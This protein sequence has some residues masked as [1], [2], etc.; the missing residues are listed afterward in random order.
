VFAAVALLI[1]AVR[2]AG[3]LAFSV[4]ARRR[5][6]GIRLTHGAQPQRLFQG[7][8]AEGAAVAAM[9][10]VAG[11]ASGFVLTRVARSYFADVWMPGL[12]PVAASAFVLLAVAVVASMLPAGRAAPSM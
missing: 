11:S 3:V 10:I 8:L 6:F 2:V 12:L 4:S 9:G 1:A 7:V 5:E